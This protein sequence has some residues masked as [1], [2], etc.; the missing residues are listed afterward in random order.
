MLRRKF[1]GTSTFIDNDDD[2]I[3]SNFIQFKV[4]RRKNRPKNVRNCKK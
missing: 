3:E 4:V 2:D 1:Y